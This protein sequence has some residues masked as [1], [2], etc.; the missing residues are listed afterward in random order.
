MRR[1]FSVVAALAC[2]C[3]L[4]ISV[5]N[6]GGPG[7]SGEKTA[8]KG[9]GCTKTC[10]AAGDGFPAMVMSVN[11]KNFDC[12][13][14]AAKA[15]KDSN[16]KVTYIVGD[17]K[18]DCKD[19]ATVA[20]ADMS[21]RYVGR[22][23][24]IACVADG[25]V[26]Y[27]SDSAGCCSSKGAAMASAKSCSGEAASAKSGSC[28]HAASA[29]KTDGD[30]KSDGSTKTVAAGESK[31]SCCKSGATAMA[32]AE[33]GCCKS[34]Q[35]MSSKDIE[36]CCKNAK[37]VKYMVL[38]RTFSKRDE[39]ERALKNAH[40]SIKAIKMAYIVDGKQVDNAADVCPM[41]KAA[42]KVVYLVNQQKIN[43][44]FEARIALARA[45]YDAAKNF[46]ETLAGI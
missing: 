16:T 22:Y 27:C 24:T 33:G 30:A 6:A 29:A 35:M 12:C 9:E 14:A 2:I 13:L 11:G 38:G 42:G 32:K 10:S 20:L 23:M 3:T 44:E 31:A 46:A 26:M 40:D 4:G 25:K 36:A 21:E 8:A 18:F 19:K 28:P 39:A 17:E 41:A 43:C 5:T 1:V 45:Q 37:E 34:G 15:A 7:C